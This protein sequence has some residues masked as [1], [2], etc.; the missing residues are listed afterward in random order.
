MGP[1]GFEHPSFLAEKYIFSE[2][3]LPDGAKT[4]ALNDK[5]IE[6]YP[7]LQEVITAWSGLPDHIKKNIIELIQNISLGKGKEINH[8]DTNQE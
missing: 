2:N 1:H 5:T 4:G 3:A 6:K 8:A 7:E